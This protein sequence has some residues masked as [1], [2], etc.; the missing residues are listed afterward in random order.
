MPHCSVDRID[1]LPPKKDG[2][3]SMWN[4]GHEIPLLIKLR[5]EVLAALNGDSPLVWNISIVLRIHV[6]PR[7]NT[8]VG[9]LDNFIT[10]I[11]DGLQ[12]AHQNTPFDDAWT[13][14]DLESIHPSKVIAI[15]DDKEV[16]SIVAEKI[17]DDEDTAH[18]YSI[19]LTGKSCI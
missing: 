17:L 16:I 6:G 15:E 10:G 4:N 11:C 1:G 9:D 3:N 7:T 13:A 19:E 2:A 18:W 8:N 12:K 14:P 5:K